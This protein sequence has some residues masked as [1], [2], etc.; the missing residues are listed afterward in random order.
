[1]G[2]SISIVMKDGSDGLQLAYNSEYVHDQM[3]VKLSSAPVWISCTNSS[4][5]ILPNESLPVP[6]EFNTTDLE[7]GTY[8]CN[9]IITSND[10]VNPQLDIP[11]TLTVSTEGFHS[12]NF[13]ITDVEN[14]PVSGALINLV[15]QDGDEDHNYSIISGTDG[16]ATMYV[17]EGIYDLNVTVDGY[18]GY[19]LDDISISENNNFQVELE[20]TNN[21]E[22]GV[23]L[24]KTTLG[25]NYP[26]PF[27][28]ETN[29]SFFLQ[30]EEAVEIV[31]YNIKG[32]I[33]KTLVNDILSNGNH[34]LVWKGNNEAGTK[35]SSGVYYYQ[36]KTKTY[37]SM[38]KM[39][40]LK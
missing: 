8:N 34:S 35:V 11:V 1:V 21:N 25:K 33:V 24:L 5:T 7:A 12:I 15:N 9:I 17:V 2:Q 18:I 16:L 37:S 30:E 19:T 31:I 3:A 39:L 26:N 38:K 20:S 23:E 13:E 40:L 14:S 27:N 6:I 36:M 28:P 32:Q 10:P 22:D 4:G 29:I